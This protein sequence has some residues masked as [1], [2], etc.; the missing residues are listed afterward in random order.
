MSHDELDHYRTM[1]LDTLV[2]LADLADRAECL[3]T[4][5]SLVTNK[6]GDKVKKVQCHAINKLISLVKTHQTKSEMMAL[7]MREIS[8]FME[9]AGTKP[10]HRIYALGFLNKVVGTFA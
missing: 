9:R 10:S 8:L 1:A 2:E 3:Q 4:V 7:V 6:F 5:V